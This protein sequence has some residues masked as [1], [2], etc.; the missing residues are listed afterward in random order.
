AADLDDQ[1][2]PVYLETSR[3]GGHLWLFFP[4]SVAGRE[5][6]QFGQGLLATY[7]LPKLELFPKQDRLRE[8]PGSLIRIPFGI[9]RRTG[10][11]YRF[12]D[13]HERSLGGSWLAQI[14]L[15]CAPQTVPEP[16]FHHFQGLAAKRGQKPVL[17]SPA[18]SEVPLSQ[19]LKAHISVLDFVS[20]YVELAPNGRGLCPFHDDRHASF[21]VNVEQNYWHCFAGCGGGSVIDFWMK[22]QA[23]DFKTAVKELDRKLL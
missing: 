14:Q 16:A 9:H 19:R 7:S 12:I 18:L 21:G 13:L 22:W 4:R 5:A 17:R 2:I 1:D 23:C 10:Q 15:L 20:Q 3:R 6:R 8:G 11:R